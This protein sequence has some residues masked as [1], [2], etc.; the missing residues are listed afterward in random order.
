MIQR[1][2]MKIS[3]VVT[4]LT[5]NEIDSLMLNSMI[6]NERVDL[7]CLFLTKISLRSDIGPMRWVIAQ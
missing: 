3:K 6:L 5:D 1:C 2:R 4:A 7:V